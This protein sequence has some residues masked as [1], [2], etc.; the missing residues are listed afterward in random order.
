[1]A[2]IVSKASQDIEYTAWKKGKN[3]L[4][5]KEMSVTI[6]GGANVVDKTLLK[7]PNGIVTEVTAEELEFLKQQVAFNNHCS[8]GWMTIV[9]SKDAANKLADNQSKDEEGQIKKD[10]SAQLTAED[11]ERNGQKA[12]LVGGKE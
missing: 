9:K 12:P 1:M 4:N 6:R 8:R 3:G 11:F 7:S 10:G 2:Y 5:Q